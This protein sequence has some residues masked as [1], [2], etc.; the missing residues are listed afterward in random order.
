[1]NEQVPEP[2]L[3][4]VL[5]GDRLALA[6]L[7][8]LFEDSSM[9]LGLRAAPACGADRFAL[10]VGVTGPPGAGKSSLT[11]ALTAHVRSLGHRVGVLAVDPSSPKTGGALM[12]DR[13]RM[14]QHTGDTEVFIR[15]LASRGRIG[16]LADVLPDATR[17]LELWGAEVIFVE[18]V[19]IGQSAI[20]VASAVDVTLLVVPPGSG[21]D[22]QAA[23]AGVVEI[24]DVIAVNKSDTPGAGALA[25]SIRTMLKLHDGAD[26]TVVQTA[27]ITGD[28]V[29]KLWLH[30]DRRLSLEAIEQRRH[31]ASLRRLAVVVG[32]AAEMLVT[33]G[34]LRAGGLVEDCLE[35][36]A[37]VSDLVSWLAGRLTLDQ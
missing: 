8:S 7:M 35:G 25:S 15:G 23:K 9:T 19:G 17:A 30:L 3:R 14:T 26:V 34:R 11:S 37:P 10:V 36:R 22:I 21:D 2:L 18:T 29:A 13:V 32:N 33:D 27:A 20:E 24:A 6:R 12:G 1:V 4:R 28:G 5:G 16:G 31:F